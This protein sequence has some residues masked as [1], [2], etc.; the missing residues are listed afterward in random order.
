MYASFLVPVSKWL[1]LNS[2]HIPYVT[3]LK[4]DWPNFLRILK[5]V[6]YVPP[7]NI[8]VPFCCLISSRLRNRLAS[9]ANR[10]AR[11]ITARDEN[12]IKRAARE[13]WAGEAGEAG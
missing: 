6:I 11:Y 13:K 3:V 12:A 7:Y 10:S 4:N 1:I 8:Y 5:V 2:A 9:Y